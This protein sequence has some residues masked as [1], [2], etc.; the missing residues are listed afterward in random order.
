[1]RQTGTAKAGIKVD[2]KSCKNRKTIKNT[3]KKASISVV[4]TEE[5]EA[6]KKRETSYP[7]V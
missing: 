3:S 1:M 6:S 4:I 7:K 2:L 5:I